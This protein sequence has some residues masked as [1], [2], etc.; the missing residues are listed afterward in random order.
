MLKVGDKINTLDENR[1]LIVQQVLPKGFTSFDILAKYTTPAGVDSDGNKVYGN[2]GFRLS[3]K[4][5]NGFSQSSLIPYKWV[6]LREL[7]A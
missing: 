5:I 1:E 3:D 2:R 4:G 6:V 7:Y